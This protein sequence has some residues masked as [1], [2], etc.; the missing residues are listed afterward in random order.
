VQRVLSVVI[1]A[2]IFIGLPLLLLGDTDTSTAHANIL[3]KEAT[4]SMS[5]ASNSSA[6]AA[7]TARMYA[8]E[9]E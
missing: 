9:D 4:G 1:L 3:N 2:I 5:K 8:V 6:G 7:T